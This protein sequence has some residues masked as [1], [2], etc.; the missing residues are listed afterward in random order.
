MLSAPLRALSDA[1]FGLMARLVTAWLRLGQAGF[2]VPG[3]R[4][5]VNKPPEPDRAQR[6]ATAAPMFIREIGSDE[7][8]KLLRASDPQDSSRY[9]TARISPAGPGRW[10][11]AR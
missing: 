9:S 10:I 11:A 3:H 4:L 8:N 1:A 6:A 2:G 7:A 5:A